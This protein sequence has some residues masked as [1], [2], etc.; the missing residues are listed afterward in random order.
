[1]K[2]GRSVA[3][4]GEGG[5]RGKA[6]GPRLVANRKKPGAWSRQLMLDKK[7]LVIGK[8]GGPRNVDLKSVIPPKKSM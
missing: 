7:R 1:M 8:V 2:R 3:R 5:K 4:G 6:V